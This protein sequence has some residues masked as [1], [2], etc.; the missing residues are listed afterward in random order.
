[1]PP[2]SERATRDGAPDA[3]GRAPPAAVPRGQLGRA[4]P[5]VDVVK[6]GA[7]SAR[8]Q[9]RRRKVADVDEVVGDRRPVAGTDGARHVSFVALARPYGTLTAIQPPATEERAHARQ[10]ATGSRNVLEH[11]G[12]RDRVEARVAGVNVCTLP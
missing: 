9:R 2:G 3:P 4:R 6:A 8:A 12:Q 10:H 1:M 5:D 11:V 7:L